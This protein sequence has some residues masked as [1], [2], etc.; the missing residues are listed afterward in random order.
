MNAKE[1]RWLFGAVIAALIVIVNISEPATYGVSQEWTNGDYRFAGGTHP[2]ALTLALLIA[3]T[4]S[5]AD[6]LSANQSRRTSAD[7]VQAIRDFLA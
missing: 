4:L 1:L 6:V 2:V 3:G 7:G 5:A